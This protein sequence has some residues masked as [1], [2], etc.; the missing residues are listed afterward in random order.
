MNDF[1]RIL[2]ILILSSAPLASGVAASFPLAASSSGR[3]WYADAVNGSD[4]GAGTSWRTAKRTLQAAIDLAV[5][6]DE[7]LVADGIFAPIVTDNK[8]IVIR[9]VNGARKTFIDGGGTQTCAVLCPDGI[10]ERWNT[11]LVGFTI[12]NGYCDREGGSSGVRH[13]I[14]RN[15]IVR[16]NETHGYSASCLYESRAYNCLFYGNSFSYTT[17]V[18]LGEYPLTYSG[19]WGGGVIGWSNIY[20]CTIV[21]ND[22]YGVWDCYTYNSIVWGNADDIYISRGHTEESP[23]FSCYGA[24]LYDGEG[25][26]KVDPKFVDA[27][28]RDYRLQADSPCINAGSNTY[29]GAG[30]ADLAGRSRIVKD[31]VDMGAYEYGSKPLLMRFF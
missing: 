5:D 31:T 3:T 24:S 26:I 27:A 18:Y 1:L 9:S 8:A 4:A 30:D 23:V 14:I 11:I 6:G 29:V 19:I 13:G 15:C 20:N 10:E 16:N 2:S 28:N 12:Q 17:I 21:D 7:I 25:S 22:A